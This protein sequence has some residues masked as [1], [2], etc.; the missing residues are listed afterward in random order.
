MA[1]K[2]VV[3]LRALLRRRFALQLLKKVVQSEVDPPDIS[4]FFFGMRIPIARICSLVRIVDQ[5]FPLGLC[6]Q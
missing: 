3:A 4:M 6:L 1:Q 5:P 2:Q